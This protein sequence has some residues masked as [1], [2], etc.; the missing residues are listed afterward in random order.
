MSLRTYYNEASRLP[1]ASRAFSL[2]P[3]EAAVV[4][5]DPLI[6]PKDAKFQKHA[7]SVMEYDE[8]EHGNAMWTPRTLYVTTDELGRVVRHIQPDDA[9]VCLMVT[10]V[11]T[12]RT[13]ADGTIKLGEDGRELFSRRLTFAPYDLAE[14]AMPE[15]VIPSVRHRLAATAV[16]SERAIRARPMPKPLT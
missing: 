9:R 8:D 1:G 12:P 14:S 2:Q 7:V 6:D 4:L 16:A 13:N 5:F 11:E 15:R 10:C 3:G